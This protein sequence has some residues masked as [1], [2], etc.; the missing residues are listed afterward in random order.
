VPP[1]PDAVALV[2][3]LAIELAEC[4]LRGI[5]R[6]DLR[7]HNQNRV[8]ANDLQRLAQAYALAEGLALHSR[9]AQIK[10]LL[11]DA[12]GAMADDREPAATLVRD[13]LFGDPPPMVEDA[14]IGGPVRVGMV[15]RSAGDLLDQ[16]FQRSGLTRARFDEQRK[17]AFLSFGEFLVGFCAQ[18]LPAQPDDPVDPA[19]AEGV[20]T[21]GQLADGPGST[22]TGPESLRTGYVDDGRFVQLL[23]EAVNATIVGF[24]NEHLAGLLDRALTRKIATRGSP[25]AF[26]AS[27]RV[28]FCADRLLESIADERRDFPDPGE[29]V[30]QRR[31]AAFYGRRSL[32]VFLRRKIR[33]TRWPIYES[34]FL[35]PFTGTLFEL[36]TGQRMIHLLV[37]SPQR[38]SSGHLYLEFAETSDQYFTG[39][40]EDIVHNSVADNTIIPVG[41]P[42]GATFE[43]TGTRYRHN[44]LID[45]SGAVGWL[46]YV[47]VVTWRQRAGRAEPLLQLCTD[48]NST[49]A[50][51][52][53]MHPATHIY[54]VDYDTPAAR[55]AA[56]PPSQIDLGDAVPQRAARRRLMLEAGQELPGDLM[57]V[58]TTQYLNYDREHLYFFVYARQVPED[59]QFP[60]RAE[61][62]HVPL[63][64]LLAI[65]ENQA[66]RNA[67][68]LLHAP[69]MSGRARSAATEIVALNLTLHGHGDLA[70]ALTAAATLH[71]WPSEVR[72]AVSDL[73]E[74]TRQPWVSGGREFDMKGLAGLEYREF[75]ST[76][77]PLYA[78]LG[79]PGAADHLA[80]LRAD[81]ARSAAITRLAELYQDVD[82]ITDIPAEL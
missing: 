13:L 69:A 19:D 63:Q 82:V 16:A 78:R 23:S 46:A 67:G 3:R 37:R 66:L 44:V 70:D 65:L 6:L 14:V 1:E 4:R 33:A 59:F 54:Q 51:D 8:A 74:R 55:T 38:S 77:L 18:F 35:P 10:Q 31:L 29:A 76:L 68:R 53:L 12:I 26:W 32:T 40:F 21:F 56:I 15:T 64:E 61:M 73:I 60:R 62:H 41:V 42:R 58:G 39:V 48:A 79:V 20:R 75:F 81:A 22:G 52:R 71:P 17:A 50:L 47:L 11:W 80:S 2:R 7:T 34:S 27:L 28:V 43:R 57:P 30:R 9:T 45:R 72:A 25:D 36:P 5:E 49:R 24:T